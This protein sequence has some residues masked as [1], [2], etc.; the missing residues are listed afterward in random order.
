[1]LEKYHG[2]AREKVIKKSQNGSIQ[3]SYFCLMIEAALRMYHFDA[4]A[5]T[6][7]AFYSDADPYPAC[8]FDADPYPD[9][10]CH[11][12]AD[13]DPTFQFDGYPDPQHWIEGSG[14]V[15]LTN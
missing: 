8:R 10:T 9:P 11:L 3:V 14:F 5:D 2:F 1:M 13:P 7:P 4:D 6:D 15:P 12:D